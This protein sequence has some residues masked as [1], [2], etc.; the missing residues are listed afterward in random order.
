MNGP[1]PPTPPPSEGEGKGE[2]GLKMKDIVLYMNCQRN[3]SSRI[4]FSKIKS[5]DGRHTQ[6]FIKLSPL[7]FI[8][9]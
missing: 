4:H 1:P 3:D 7:K 5:I 9:D 2:G 8:L 6:L